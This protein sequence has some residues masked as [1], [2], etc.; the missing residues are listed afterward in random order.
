MD[1]YSKNYIVLTT[2]ICRRKI[3]SAFRPDISANLQQLVKSRAFTSS[4][5][6]IVDSSVESPDHRYTS[7]R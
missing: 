3:Q 7:D 6:E 2:K 4:I 1:V 5:R